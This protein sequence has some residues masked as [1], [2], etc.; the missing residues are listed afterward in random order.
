[1]GGGWVQEPK[2]GC[3][4]QRVPSPRRASLSPPAVPPRFTSECAGFTCQEAAPGEAPWRLQAPGALRCVLDAC[5]RDAWVQTEAYVCLRNCTCPPGGGPCTLLRECGP[6]VEIHGGGGGGGKEGRRGVGGG[7]FFFWVLFFA[8][9]GAAAA[10]GFIHVQGVPPWLPIRSRG[11][12]GVGLY[13]EL[14]EHEGI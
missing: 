12:G 5:T 13:Q 14:S 2:E 1:M 9:A 8:A 6:K 10:F 11:F 3:V 4:L 7:A